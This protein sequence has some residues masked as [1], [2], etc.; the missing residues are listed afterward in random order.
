M[1]AAVSA[2][3]PVPPRLGFKTRQRQQ[4]FHT[5]DFSL[6]HIPVLVHQSAVILT[7]ELAG[8]VRWPQALVSR[9]PRCSEVPYIQLW[10]C[11]EEIRHVRFSGCCL[12]P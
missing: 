8:R 10:F 3:G 1:A 2:W 5:P 4:G 12:H 6:T 9:V 7:R 11:F